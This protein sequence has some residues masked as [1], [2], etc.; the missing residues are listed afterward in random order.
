MS[1]I[2]IQIFISTF[3]RPTLHSPKRWIFNWSHWIIGNF[4]LIL[5]SNQL[6]KLWNLCFFKN[7]LIFEFILY[8]F[9]KVI[10]IYCSL[11][12]RLIKTR[13]NQILWLL[14]A[15]VM[16]TI[17]TVVL[18]EI[19]DYYIRRKRRIKNVVNNDIKMKP[20]ERKTKTVPNTQNVSIKHCFISYK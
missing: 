17:L 9:S 12:Y 3:F 13:R 19:H 8:L 10:T 2:V 6:L 15:M 4:S 11:D 16:F 18:L 20:Y 5:S 1:L 14:N 7:K